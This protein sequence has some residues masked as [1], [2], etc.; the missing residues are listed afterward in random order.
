MPSRS[1]H[2]KLP[3][4]GVQ[5]AC[6][7]SKPPPTT[8]APPIANALMTDA[9]ATSPSTKMPAA[10][11][12]KPRSS[13]TQEGACG[14]VLRGDSTTPF[15][16]AIV[17]P[18][19]GLDTYDYAS[20]LPRSPWDQSPYGRTLVHWTLSPPRRIIFRAAAAATV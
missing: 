14:A 13:A 17:V 11:S 2:A 8:A 3:Q 20:A 6:A 5:N 12:T 4:A 10:I 15:V 7:I 18:F 1:R 16:V 19:L 9:S